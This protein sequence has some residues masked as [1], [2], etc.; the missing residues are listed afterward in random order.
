[1]R[2]EELLEECI[3]ALRSGQELSPEAARYL[4]RHPQ[5]RTELED[6]LF[7]ARQASHLPSAELSPQARQRMQS[8]LAQRLGFDASVLDTAHK[9]TPISADDEVGLHSR[10][11]AKKP[12]LSVGRLSLSRLR[13]S[14]PANVGPFSDASI[15]EVFRDLTP[16]DIR[17]YIGVRGEDY[18]HYRRALP[19]WRPVFTFLAAVLRGFKRLEQLVTVE[20][21]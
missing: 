11:R 21:R 3:L 19:G 15:R 5:K 8:R 4:A 20:S 9:S 10:A 7:V 2:N 13:Y 18:L 14:P 6:L 12:L 1:M 16:E 17:R